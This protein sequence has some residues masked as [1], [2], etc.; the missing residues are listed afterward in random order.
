MITF[1]IKT[2]DKQIIIMIKVANEGILKYNK[3]NKLTF[4]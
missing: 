3:L 2:Y 1:S 4:S